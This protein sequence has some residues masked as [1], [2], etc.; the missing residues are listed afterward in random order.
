MLQLTNLKE[1]MID[2]P[3]TLKGFRDF[4]PQEKRQRDFVAQKVK[5]V[6]ELYGFEPLETPALEYASLLLGK[7]GDEADKLVYTFA[8]RGERQIGLRY[9]QT[10]PTSRVLGQY[11]NE[12]PRY[13][14]RYQMQNV[15][16][17]DKPQKGRF[18]EFTQFDFDIF[19][20]TSP[21]ADAEIL[22]CVY[23][24]FRAIGF[25]NI[26]LKLN[27]RQTLLSNL[28]PFATD[29]LNVFSIIQSIDKLDKLTPDQVMD[30]LVSKGLTQVS[31]QEI[32]ERLKVSLPSGNLQAIIKA[33]LQLGIPESAMVFDSALARGLDYY[34]GM[35]FEVVCQEY[36]AGSCAG[37]GRYDNL[38]NDLCGL[39]MPAVG[40]ALGFDRVVEAALQLNLIP[41]EATGTQVMVTVFDENSVPTSL[42]TAQKLR[43]SGIKTEVFPSLDKLGKQFKLADQKKIPAVIIIGENEIAE[44]KVTLKNMQTGEQELMTLDA[45]IQRLK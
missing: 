32:L 9:D 28:E 10:V 29:S 8:D 6:C 34:T 44:N 36:S 33:A 37:G 21:L 4:L 15:F 20:S 35:I 25:K 24:S 38:I 17:A 11:Q 5:Q 7:Y 1:H 45:V 14:R 13:F 40:V 42:A 3:Q 27:D 19:G 18:R 16:R 2:Q 43:A 23:D 26:I 12:L 30:E 31:T 22:A 39:A 41:T